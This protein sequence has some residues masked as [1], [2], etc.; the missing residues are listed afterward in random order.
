MDLGKIPKKG[1]PGKVL[2]LPLRLIPDRARMPILQGRLRGK[3][4]IAGSSTNHGFWL[5]TREYEQRRVFED[6]VTEGSIVFDVGAH[7]GFYTMLA[8]VISGPQGR[9]FAFEP[10][11][12]NLRFLRE[13]LR[14][15]GMDGVQV[16]EAAVSDHEGE[17]VFAEGIGSFD[18]R[19][20]DDGSL[21]VRTLT[22]DSLL[23]SGQVPAPDFIKMDVEGGELA[24]LKGARTL[25]AAHHPTIFL[26]THGPGVH[27]DC[28]ELLEG[29]GYRFRFTDGRNR[30]ESTEVLATAAGRQG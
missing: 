12:A 26:A 24:A 28:L 6:T 16:F 14:I 17:A 5:G 22:L 29:L 23:E 9:V 20:A 7:V 3:R 13:H 30:A 2:R 8:T 21:R 25:L 11:P 1:L 19:L 18:G 15:N 27:R 10:L 4:W